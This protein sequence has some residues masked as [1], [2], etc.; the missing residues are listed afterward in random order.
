MRGNQ[1]SFLR[2]SLLI[3][4][5]VHR[6]F[7]LSPQ[8]FSTSASLLA[9]PP[10]FFPGHSSSKIDFAMLNC[11]DNESIN[12]ED[13]N[14][15]DL[16]STNKNGNMKMMKSEVLED[17]NDLAF[18]NFEDVSAEELNFANDHSESND[19]QKLPTNPLS[20]NRSSMND[21]C[22][23]STSRRIW[24]PSLDDVDKISRG[25]GA[26]VRGTGSRAVPHRLNRDERAEYE[27]AQRKGFLELRSN[28]GYRKERKGSP[29]FNIW[30]QW[31]DCH[32]AP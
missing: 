26:R 8:Y 31:N 16:C 32:K 2:T 11:S 28:A 18:S 10:N 24:R 3:K 15:E 30:R 25:Q 17:L 19:E 29:L 1:L 4:N 23:V 5:L 27:R 14:V 20:S 9:N 13:G 12:A 21:R 22:N 7:H 6:N